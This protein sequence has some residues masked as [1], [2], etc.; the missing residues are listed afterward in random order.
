MC[1]PIHAYAFADLHESAFVVWAE[2]PRVKAADSPDDAFH[3]CGVEV[4]ARRAGY[5]AFV[6]SMVSP[7]GEPCA[8][9]VAGVRVAQ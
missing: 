8:E 3:E 7:K 2:F 9:S 4:F 5:D 1:G 6:K